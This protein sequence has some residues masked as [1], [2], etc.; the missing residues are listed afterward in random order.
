MLF[1]KHLT[2]MVHHHLIDLAHRMA[3][4]TPNPEG[5][6]GITR[7]ASYPMK[8]WENPQYSCPARQYLRC[9]SI[10]ENTWTWQLCRVQRSKLLMLHLGNEG[11]IGY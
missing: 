11:T 6:C 9:S 10:Q 7:L 4:N 5:Q 2:Y 3:R 1:K 8:W